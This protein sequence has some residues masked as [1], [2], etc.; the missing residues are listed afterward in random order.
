MKKILIFVLLFLL[1]S[2]VFA[3]SSIIESISEVTTIKFTETLNKKLPTGYKV[4]IDLNNGNGFTSMSCSATTCTLSSNISIK[5][6]NSLNYKLGIFDIKGVMQGATTAPTITKSVLAA[7]KFKFT[8][9]L[10]EQ[11]PI[12]YKIKI[13]LNNG[14]GLVA[15]S[16]SAIT[17][18]LSSNTLPKNIDSSYNTGVY[19]SKGV[20]Q[21]SKIVGNYVILYSPPLTGYTKI[22]NTGKILPETAK[23]GDGLS[24]WACTKDNKTGL[25]WEIKTSNGLYFDWLRDF[26]KVYSNYSYGQTDHDSHGNITGYGTLYNSDVF[27]KDINT[28]SLCGASNWRLPTKEELMTLVVCQDG[29]YDEDGGCVYINLTNEPTINSTYFPNTQRESFWTSSVYGIC[30]AYYVNF[31]N[32]YSNIEIKYMNFSVRLVR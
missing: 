18:T 2:N 11:L 7:T 3:I 29:K 13:D 30:C 24:D 20:L 10:S 25:I 26:K 23:L 31:L 14:K 27:V 22:S 4:K 16:C 6:I 32:G 17:C 5:N 15:M 1:N 9:T 19:D 12:G 21:G 8:V 28:K